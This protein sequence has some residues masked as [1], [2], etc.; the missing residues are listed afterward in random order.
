MQVSG[1]EER[2]SRQPSISDILDILNKAMEKAPELAL[3]LKYWAESWVGYTYDDVK[4]YYSIVSRDGLVLAVT[5]YGV[6]F[7][8]LCEG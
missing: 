7:T 3:N 1:G 2:Q 6:S 8:H 4:D 5:R